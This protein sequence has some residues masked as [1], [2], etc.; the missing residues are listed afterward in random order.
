[1]SS[2]RIDNGI[3]GDH[4][5]WKVR[6][7]VLPLAANTCS[8]LHRFPVDNWT[9]AQRAGLPGCWLQQLRC[10]CCSRQLQRPDGCGNPGG[11]LARRSVRPLRCQHPSDCNRRL[12]VTS[13]VTADRREWIKTTTLVIIEIRPYFPAVVVQMNEKLLADGT[14]T[15]TV[16]PGLLWA[17]VFFLQLGLFLQRGFRSPTVNISR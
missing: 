12:S 14:A 6:L 16:P 15:T 10:C 2:C 4:K 9:T 5:K 17:N 1:M 13:H 3:F 7:S 8:L 11:M